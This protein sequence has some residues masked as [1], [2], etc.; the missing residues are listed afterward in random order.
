MPANPGGWLMTAAKRRALDA[1]RRDTMRT[2]KHEEIAR[3]QD[4]ASDGAEACDR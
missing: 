2:R 4:E 3:E 1:I